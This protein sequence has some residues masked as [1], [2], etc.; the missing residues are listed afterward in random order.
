MEPPDTVA[1]SA[2]AFTCVRRQSDWVQYRDAAYVPACTREERE[3][4]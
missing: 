3:V 4:G 2:E 1:A